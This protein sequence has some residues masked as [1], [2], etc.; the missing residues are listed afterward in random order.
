MERSTFLHHSLWDALTWFVSIYWIYST[1]ASSM[2]E[3]VS[4]KDVTF[5]H[6]CSGGSKCWTCIDP[7][8]EGL[9]GSEVGLKVRSKGSVWLKIICLWFPRY[10][11]YRFDI[12]FVVNMCIRNKRPRPIFIPQNPLSLETSPT[13]KKKSKNNNN[14]K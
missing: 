14:N 3:G 6:Y 10:Y 11:M 4:N 1:T 9:T 12:S 2:V 8:T 13:K 5:S 7:F